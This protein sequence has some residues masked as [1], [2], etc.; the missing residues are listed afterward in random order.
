[1]RAVEVPLTGGLVTLID[2][3]D[4]QLVCE[5]KWEAFTDPDGVV[6][7]RSRSGKPR[8]FLHNVLMCPARG[9]EVDHVNHDALDNRRTN[10]RLGTRSQNLANRRLPRNS[11]SGFKGAS[12]HGASGKWRGQIKVDGR[13]LH[14]GLFLTAE[15]AARAYDAAALR[16]FGEFSLLNFPLE[17][18]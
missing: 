5:R 4:L 10:L 14:L 18:V 16:H 6:Y 15:E 13:K 1:M 2:E 17:A 12:F 9:L 8:V 11:T 3:R 7:A